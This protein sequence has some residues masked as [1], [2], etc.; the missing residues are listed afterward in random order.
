VELIFDR[1]ELDAFH[2]GVRTHEFDLHRF[3]A[4]ALD[5]TECV[6]RATG[7]TARIPA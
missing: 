4:P 7:F 2:H 3:T 5:D 1:A 6:A